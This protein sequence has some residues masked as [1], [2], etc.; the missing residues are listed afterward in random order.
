[1]LRF[2]LPQTLTVMLFWGVLWTDTVLLGRFGTAVEVGIYAVATR[3]LMPAYA[4]ATAIG[5][6]FSP[7]IAAED[8][9][10]D[11]ATLARMLKRV[12]YW[13]TSLSIPIFLTLALIPGALLAL[14]GETYSLGATA[15]AILALGQL[16]NT[17]AGPLGQVI[18]MSGRAH[19]NMMNNAAVAGL[20]VV[21][22]IVLIPRFGMVGAALSFARLAGPR[23]RAQ[24]RA[25]AHHL[26]HLSVSGRHPADT[27][28]RRSRGR[29]RG[30]GRL[31]RQ[32]VEP[33]PRK[34]P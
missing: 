11:R 24:A 33:V 14:F 13:N 1:M 17:A 22:C 9:R 27:G 18:N 16:L 26:R 2:S 10:G 34:S 8:A 28:R 3:W 7:R 20:N 23:E 32:L 29:R 6:M 12:T 21:A 5:Q 31:S 30:T 25:G 19:I 4:I 15:L